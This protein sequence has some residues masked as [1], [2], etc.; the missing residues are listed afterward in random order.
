MGPG[1]YHHGHLPRTFRP[2]QHPPTPH[3]Y[4]PTHPHPH[5]ELCRPQTQSCRAWPKGAAPG[6]GGGETGLAGLRT[7]LPHDLPSFLP[8][9][10]SPPSPTLRA[11]RWHFSY[12]PPT[13]IP[14]T[15]SGSIA[16]SEH[17]TTALGEN[18]SNSFKTLHLYIKFIKEYKDNADVVKEAIFEMMELCVDKIYAEAVTVSA[19]KVRVAE[20]ERAAAPGPLSGDA[21]GG[22]SSVM[23]LPGSGPMHTEAVAPG[24]PGGGKEDSRSSSSSTGAAILGGNVGGVALPGSGPMHTQAVAP[25]IPGGGKEDSRSSSSSTG[26]A[27]LGGNVGGV[28]SSGPPPRSHPTASSSILGRPL[29]SPTAAHDDGSD[30]SAKR[31][32]TTTPAPLPVARALPTTAP[33]FTAPTAPPL[34]SK[35]QAALCTGCGGPLWGH[36]RGKEHQQCIGNCMSCGQ[37]VQQH[38]KDGTSGRLLSGTRCNKAYPDTN[39]SRH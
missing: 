7:R 24:I 32:R 21:G 15:S 1:G 8:F 3:Y 18:L 34:P 20:L 26:A 39:V 25:G 17:D 28:A 4:L 29:D 16:M 10:P 11:H 37:P 9:P 23:A 2:A 19:L 31:A 36:A 33:S 27:I 14:Q 13:P 35:H 22:T 12:P 38:D 5:R 6:H 30:R